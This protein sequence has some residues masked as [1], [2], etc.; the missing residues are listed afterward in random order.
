MRSVLQSISYVED[1]QKLLTKER[2][3]N[4]RKTKEYRPKGS[5]S[6]ERQKVQEKNLGDHSSR[7]RF[8]R[9]INYI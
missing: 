3:S 5:V 7:L 8:S 2:M 4:G 1:S 9:I 6:S